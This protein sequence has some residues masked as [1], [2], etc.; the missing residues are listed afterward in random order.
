M[1]SRTGDVLWLVDG[2]R[3]NNRLY[4]TTPPLDTMPAGIVDRIEVLS[5]GQALFYGTQAVAGAVNIVTKPFSDKPSGS[6]T[7]SDD[8]HASRHVD[9]NFA[10]GTTLGQIVVYG[11]KDKSD[12]YDAF[13]PQDY[14]PSATS[15]KRGYDV[16]TIG[17]KYGIDFSDA[18]RLA[19]SYQHTDAD[20]D[21]ALPFRVQRDV[22]SRKEDIATVKVD[23]QASSNF[24]LFVKG[25]YHNWHTNY[26][27]FYNDL[28]A[29]G[30]IDVL[31]DNAF[32]GYK[33][34]GV[35]A[36]G[37]L[38]I[39]QGVEA[40]FGYDLQSYGGRDEV[41]VIEQHNEV[42][43]AGF[44]QLRLTNLA[45]GL[46]LAAGVR[47]NRPSVGE[48]A[49][50]W[51]VSGQYELPASMY[52]KG[53]VGTN[54]RLPDAEELFANDPQDELGNPNLKPERSTSVN[55]SFGGRPVLGNQ[56]LHWEITGFARDITNLIDYGDFNA[57]TGQDVF[58]NVPG[59]VHVRGGQALLETDFGGNLSANANYTFNSARVDG[60]QLDRIPKG[61]F[62][63]GVDV[64][65][66]D[67]RFGIAATV[68]YTGDVTRSVGGT[69]IGYGKY[70]VVDLS[71]RYFLDARR[72]QVVNLSVRNL[73]N[74]EYGQPGRGCADVSTDGPYDCSAPYVYRNLGLP[75]TYAISYTYKLD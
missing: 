60:V 4:A 5:G 25:Y 16:G 28:G 33:D 38:D 42:T 71:G 3:F 2:V 23:Y 58:D 47:Y 56:R 22:N 61:L 39:A 57:T 10:T 24:G 37:K 29:P 73:L 40:Y 32:W 59:T 64:H 50:I 1:G 18:L 74:R 54:F 6:I 17:A 70:T 46:T 68:N 41:L 34:R 14:Q 52:L 63:A 48:T 7:L 62:K 36:L 9:A 13:R 69:E 75:R 21:Y 72:H 65:P 66:A 19:L 35:N 30:T 55:A 12:G 20:L 49:T 44:G 51:N 15:R 53:E 8:S 67:Q 31:Y 43:Q 27:T 11:S 26:D 45:Q